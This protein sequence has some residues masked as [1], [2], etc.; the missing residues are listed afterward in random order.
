MSELA[1]ETPTT[2]D[3]KRPAAPIPVIEPDPPKARDI[4]L[5]FMR[6]RRNLISAFG[7]AAY[8]QPVVRRSLLGTPMWI[9]SDPEAIGRV[10]L[11]NVGN[12]PKGAQQQRR[13]KPALG[14]GLVTAEGDAWRWQRRTAAPAFQHRRVAGFA[15][16]MA[17]ATQDMLARWDADGD[18]ERNVAAD[19]MALTYD[20][21]SRTIF[22]RD[23][24]TDARRMGAAFELYFETVGRLDLAA[25]LN[26]PEWVPT[27][28]RLRARP[29]LRYFH[30]E[31]GRIV[32]QRRA[33]LAEAPDEAPDDLLGML[34]GAR[35][36][37]DGKPMDE[38]QVID[39]VIT[40]IGAGH[41]TTANALSWTLYLLAEFPW[42][43]ERV[44]AEV[45]S[46]LGDDA[47]T[48]ENVQRLVYTRQ[49]LEEAMRLYPPA[50]FM[51]R[52]ARAADV[53]AGHPVKAGT[54]ILI[55]PW[56]LHRH[57]ALWD[58]PD[59]FDPDR[60]APGRREA[61]HRFAYLPFGAGPRICIG[62]AF[63]VQEA[64]IILAMI[65][66]RHR[67]TPAPGAQIEPMTAI[68][69]RPKH[70]L[71]MRLARR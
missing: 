40:F 3:P 41:E 8:E 66:R 4:A 27:I 23:A 60:F 16:S 62:M 25:F 14:E 52:E 56:I 32:R 48:A 5:F 19:M 38:R 12:Y 49:V 21:L 34:L 44:A 13:L 26:L 70:G 22:G 50:P 10:M 6:A 55:S 68:T 69:L 61:I 46:V 57:R 64:L 58:E 24:R 7:S 33:L 35:D 2:R 15:P 54:Q 9:V 59:L 17:A 1:R 47:P 42:A 71:R 53:L 37:E 65:V 20:V 39:N 28:G 11:E 36:P 43:E 31:V 18:G 67:L 63:A 51:A 29:A 45:G 30:D